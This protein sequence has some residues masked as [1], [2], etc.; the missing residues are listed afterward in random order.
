LRRRSKAITEKEFP[1]W[2]HESNNINKNELDTKGTPSWNATVIADWH[3]AEGFVR[4]PSIHSNAYQDR[5]EILKHIREHYGGEI[6]LIPGDTNTGKWDGQVFINKAFPGSGY[7]PQE[8]V[9]EAGKNCYSTTKDLFQ[10]AGYSKT[11]VAVGDH[12]LGGSK[13]APEETQ[14]QVQSEYRQAFYSAFHK[15][16]I[17]GKFFF[18]DSIGDVPS[19]PPDNQKAK[20]SFAYQYKNVLIVTVDVFN[21]VGTERFI[22]R[23]NGLGGT[24]VVTCRLRQSHLKWFREVLRAGNEEP[25]IKHI[26]VQS[27]IPVIQPVRKVACTGQFYDEGEDSKFWKAMRNNGVDLY[28]SGE[29]HTN[30]ATMDTNSNLIQVVSRGVSLNNFLT[31]EVTDYRIRLT[32]YNEVGPKAKFN[33][34]YEP[35]GSIVVD[36]S[37]DETVLKSSGV[38]KFIDR[39]AALIHFDFEKL[40][41]FQSRQVIGLKHASWKQTL[42]GS[43][44]DIRSVQSQNSFHNKGEFGG[45]FSFHLPAMIIMLCLF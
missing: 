13:W 29:V 24:G 2:I 36:K 21:K 45:R 12:E 23:K 3:S 30:T 31:M 35:F 26:I 44:M 40:E 15:E 1:K 8:S 22:D 20:T 25:S 42:I 10:E 43:E 33:K 34:K 41:P 16:E 19:S 37:G 28:L 11:I 9:L 18:P 6:A 4:D 17:N 7:T 27:H 38:L 14:V 5:L 39:T 32:A